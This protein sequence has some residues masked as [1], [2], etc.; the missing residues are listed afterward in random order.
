MTISKMKARQ[1][2]KI[3]EVGDVLVAAGFVTLDGQAVAL[4]IARSTTWTILRCN[5]KASGI[6][7]TII[8]R[9]LMSPRL[10]PLVRAKILEY[11]QEKAAGLHGH[12]PTQLRRFRARLSIQP[13]EVRSPRSSTL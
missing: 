10:P 5:H 4:G 8:N 1:A 12:S 7:A 13:T 3:K 6:S 2:S 9:M 11:I